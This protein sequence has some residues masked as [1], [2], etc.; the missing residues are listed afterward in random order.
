MTHKCGCPKGSRM[1]PY[2]PRRG[3]MPAD[4]PIKKRSPPAPPERTD[5]EIVRDEAGL[6]AQ[7]RV[8]GI[9]ND[10]TRGRYPRI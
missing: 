9:M 3:A 7:D 8:S 4:M 2:R 1:N 6:G 10:A 5:F